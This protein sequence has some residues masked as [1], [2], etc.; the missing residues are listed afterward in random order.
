MNKILDKMLFGCAYYREY[1]P[2]ERLDADIEL[3]KKAHINYVRIAES[4]W[5]TYEKEEGQFDFSSVLTVLDKMHKANIQVIVGTPTYAVPA[6]LC[7]KYPEILATTPQGKLRYGPRQQM[8][9]THPSY[10]YYAERITRKL[11]E[12]VHDHPAVIGYQLDNETKYYNCVSNNLQIA[13]VKYLKEKFKN[14]LE[15]LN[16]AYGLDYWSNRIDSW[17]DFP[18]VINTINGSLASEFK[19]FQRSLVTEFLKKLEDVVR[20]YLKP[21][22][23]ITHNFDFEWRSQSFGIQPDVD[24]FK[25]SKCLDIAGVDIYHPSQEYLTGAEIAFGGDELRS[26]KD[27][28]YFVLETQAQAF[29]NWTPF[30]GQLFLQGLAHI[31]SGASLL[32]YWHWHSIHNSFE[33]YWKGL[34]SYDF[35]E[36]AVFKEACL[37]GASIEKLEKHLVGFHKKNKC[38]LVVSNEALSAIDVFPYKGPSLNTQHFDFHQ[39]NDVVRAY[40]DAL[41]ENNIESDIRCIDDDKIFDYEL[42][43]LPLIYCLSDERLLKIREYIKHGGHVLLSFKS[44]V[45]DENLKVRTTSQPALID[46]LLGASYELIAEPHNLKLTSNILDLSKA[47]PEVHDFMDLMHIDDDRAISLATYDHKYYK[48]YAAIVYR[49]LIKE[50]ACSEKLGSISYIATCV[51]KSVIKAVVEH[52]ISDNQLFCE[53]S[54]LRFPLIVREAY[55][56]HNEKLH[57]VFNFSQEDLQFNNPFGKCISLLEDK[58]VSSSE[59]VYLKDWGACI[60]KE[61]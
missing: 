46:D 20:P 57:F 53:R 35:K 31:A 42:L 13:F 48:D 52:I 17:E 56:A 34:L 47:S 12:A 39:Y 59:I 54:S 44:F 61:I 18:D 1:M 33:T 27:Q 11:L 22:Q 5:S 37:L 58:I 7:R 4:T 2:Y 25:T 38:C 8:D 14:N 3:M 32:G 6:W 26:L 60:L 24:H 9:I 29:K 41:Y 45:T 19:R 50:E 40:Y 21:E 55:N 28:R 10:L 51:D 23:F 16:Y 49:K 36:N 30:K 15:A 43:V